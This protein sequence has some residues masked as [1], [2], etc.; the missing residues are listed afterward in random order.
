MKEI[1][2]KIAPKYFELQKAR[3]KDFEIRKDDSDYEVGDTLILKEYEIFKNKSVE[4]DYGLYT[5]KE[6]TKRIKYK[7]SAEEFS[8]GLKEGYCV[9][10]LEDIE[11]QRIKL[12]NIDL[13]NIT[14]VEQNKKIE[15]ELLEFKEAIL[16]DNFENAIEEFWDIVQVHLGL[17]Q[18]FGYLAEEVMERYPNHISKIKNRPRIKEE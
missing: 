4:G 13:S 11:N 14:L 3:I 1:E 16:D 5:G 9:L 8:E 6:I 12:V 2:K 15:E 7:I 17:L 18:K 10:G